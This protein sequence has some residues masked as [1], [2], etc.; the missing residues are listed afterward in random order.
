MIS[1]DILNLLSYFV[2]H[3][4]SAILWTIDNEDRGCNMNKGHAISH[5]REI[6]VLVFEFSG[7]WKIRPLYRYR[8]RGRGDFECHVSLLGV[9]SP[10]LRVPVLG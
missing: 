7:T 1:E 4:S 10:R 9:S 8:V 5:E 2:D 6:S 3:Y